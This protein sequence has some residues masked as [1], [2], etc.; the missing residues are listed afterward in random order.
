MQKVKIEVLDADARCRLRWLYKR[1]DTLRPMAAGGFVTVWGGGR[2]DRSLD[3]ITP[4]R[5]YHMP[6]DLFCTPR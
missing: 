1:K 2:S 5:P 3:C 4:G 6:L